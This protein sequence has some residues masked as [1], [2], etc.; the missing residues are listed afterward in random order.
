[1]VRRSTQ[2]FHANPEKLPPELVTRP[3]KRWFTVPTEP[4]ALVEF[5]F[6]LACDGERQAGQ[7]GRKQIDLV[8]V[9]ATIEVGDVAVKHNPQRPVGPQ[10]RATGRIELR[11]CEMIETFPSYADSLT[12]QSA[13]DRRG[14]SS[15]KS[16]LWDVR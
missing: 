16:G 3:L 12:A 14:T 7:S 2:R 4:V 10:G 11:Q 1:M 13:G 5:P 9:A 6:L 15:A 8:P